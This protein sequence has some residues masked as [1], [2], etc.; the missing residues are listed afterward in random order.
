MSFYAASSFFTWP[1][2]IIECPELEGTHSDLWVQLLAPPRTDQTSDH[3]TELLDASW[4]PAAWW[5][6]CFPREPV[7]RKAP[8]L[9][10]KT[11]IVGPIDQTLLNSK[12][13]SFTGV[14]VLEGNTGSYLELYLIFTLETFQSHLEGR[15][16]AG[17]HQAHP[18]AAA[19]HLGLPLRLW[20]EDSKRGW[21]NLMLFNLSCSI[22]PQ[23]WLSVFSLA[24]TQIQLLLIS[25]LV[26]CWRKLS[27]FN[28]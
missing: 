27:L 17:R 5:H 20:A 10:L 15:G 18:Q 7:P 12:G 3:M 23:L 9:K 16:P 19:H 25:L 28:R 2:R 22:R 11:L 8:I 6:G 26:Y 21:S 24:S 14:A 4:T 13:T 1:C